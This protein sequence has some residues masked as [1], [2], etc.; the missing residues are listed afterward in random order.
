MPLVDTLALKTGLVEAGM[1]SAQADAIVHAFVHA[2]TE[3]L[4]TK[5]DV[6][7][8]DGRLDKLQWMAGVIL[9]FLLLIAGMVGRLLFTTGG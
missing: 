2:D 6:A 4:A 9:A 3:H 7:R 1:D 5:A 8:L